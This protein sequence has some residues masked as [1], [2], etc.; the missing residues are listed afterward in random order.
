M[1]CLKYFRSAFFHSDLS[2]YCLTSLKNRPKKNSC[3]W[4]WSYGLSLVLTGT[5]RKATNCRTS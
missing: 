2:T 3:E 4:G 1:Y 5:A